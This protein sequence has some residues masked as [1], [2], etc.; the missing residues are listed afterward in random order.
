LADASC[1]K[2]F[3]MIEHRPLATLGGGDHGW[4]QARLHFDF[5]GLG[6]PAHKA[7]GPLRVW[8][9]DT[10]A[11]RSGFPLHP[12]QDVEIITFVREG[13]ITHEDSLG[14]KGR[15]VAGDVQV[16]SAGTGIRHSEINA[17]DVPTKLFQIWLDTRAKGATPRWANRTFPI[18][19]RTGRFVTLASGDPDDDALYIDADAAV[20][21]ATMAA[22]ETITHDLGLD[23]RAYLVPTTGRITLNGF[24]LG[25]G[26]GAAVTGERSITITAVDDTQLVLVALN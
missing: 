8:N 25:A 12:H 18:A 1:P 13:A 3:Q 15:T 20:L 19:G 22:G 14:N 24:E 4:L 26:D 16:M 21:G 11:P 7:L 10:F 2:E 23:G 6:N 9:D 5:A 17:E